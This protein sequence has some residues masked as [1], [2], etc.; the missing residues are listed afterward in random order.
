MPRSCRSPKRTETIGKAAAFLALAL[1]VSALWRAQGAESVST[2][3]AYEQPLGAMSEAEAK[4]FQFGRALFERDWA[5]APGPEPGFDGLGPLFDRLSCDGCHTHAGAGEPPREPGFP[6]VSM[7]VRLG[8]PG[9]DA[10]GGPLPHPVYGDQLD[11]NAVPGVPIEGRVSV[12]FSESEGR[13]ADGERYSLRTPHY[14][15]SRLAFG[16]LGRRALFSARVAPAL[17]GLGLLAAVP[18][19][20]IEALAAEESSEGGVRG[21]PNRV[22]DVAGKAMRLGR[23]GWKAGVPSL[24]QQTA[25]AFNRDIGITNPLYPENDCTAA[26]T[27]CWLVAAA[28]PRHPKIGDDFLTAVT[29]FVA[30]LAPPGPGKPDDPQVKRGAALFEGAGCALCHR[31]TLETGDDPDAALAHKTIHPYTDLLL[32]DMGAGLADRRPEY[33]ASG[34]SWRTAPL[35]G[36]GLSRS[37]AGHEFL[38]HD[39]R[40]R[41]PAEAILW[42]GGEAAAAKEAFRRMSRGERAALVAFLEQL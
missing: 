31:P 4:R 26:E 36:L 6:M 27:A 9:R 16:P 33:G 40:A 17:V 42:H 21:R 38:L 37:V 24:L 19:A 25:N 29:F 1:L 2:S 28:A 7:T 22:F 3:D 34:R 20:E 39:G 32:H 8:V 12:R 30:R 15:F 35:W 23:F 13:Y 41:G 5:I 18:D 11:R 10:H 14:R